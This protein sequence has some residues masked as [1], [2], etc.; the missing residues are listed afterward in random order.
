MLVLDKIDTIRV[1][2][3]NCEKSTSLKEL[4]DVIETGLRQIGVK[5]FAYIH[6]LPRKKKDMN[7]GVVKMYFDIPPLLR[8]FYESYDFY[9]DEPDLADKPS[10]SRPFWSS[11]VKGQASSYCETLLGEKSEV[12][13]FEKV[14]ILPIFGSQLR[15]G[16]FVLEFKDPKSHPTDLQISMLQW[17]FQLAHYH[18]VDLYEMDTV[19][20]GRLTQ[21]ELEV[22]KWVA[23]GKSNSVIA[24][25]LDVSIHRINSYI[26]KI[27]LKLNVD[28]RAR[29]G[30]QGI[31]LGLI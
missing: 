16:C 10:K 14:L 20:E 3:Y 15:N 17:A 23:L 18:Y 1:F 26:R 9:S 7:S 5:S 30:V 12:P 28:D 11:A 25:I 8:D 31:T 27:F 24:D 29:A 13:G 22:L 2:A 6:L 4:N 21:G 19:S